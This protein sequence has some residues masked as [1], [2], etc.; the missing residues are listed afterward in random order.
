MSIAPITP[1]T[2]IPNPPTPNPPPPP[3]FYEELA[4]Q[5]LSLAEVWET[6][7][8]SPPPSPPPLTELFPDMRVAVF[9]IG[10]QPPPS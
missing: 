7:A 5:G 8:P 9:Q 6:G 10:Q 4:A 2:Q 3:K 1:I